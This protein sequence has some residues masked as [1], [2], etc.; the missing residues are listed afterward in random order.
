MN[1]GLILTLCVIIHTAMMLY[2]LYIGGLVVFGLGFINANI[3][4]VGALIVAAIERN[5]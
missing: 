1:I 2:G 3:F 4:A 5:K